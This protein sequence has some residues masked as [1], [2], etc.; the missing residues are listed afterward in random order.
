MNSNPTYFDSLQRVAAHKADAYEINLAILDFLFHLNVER[1][2]PFFT[3]VGIP[4]S[5]NEVKSLK[6]FLKE[7]LKE[8]KAIDVDFSHN[9]QKLDLYL[10]KA[11]NGF[12]LQL[13]TEKANSIFDW[14]AK[15]W[16]RLPGYPGQDTWVDLLYGL[17]YFDETNAQLL[18]TMRNKT[19]FRTKLE[20]AFMEFESETHSFSETLSSHF[21]KSGPLS[22]WEKYLVDNC[23]M[24]LHFTKG[25]RLADLF[26][27]QAFCR[28]WH[29]ITTENTRKEVE[30]LVSWAKEEANLMH[31]PSKNLELVFS[32]CAAAPGSDSIKR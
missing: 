11:R 4:I 2:D 30:S 22:D 1:L 5:L 12:T 29:K 21:E 16:P 13:G 19:R 31:Y 8:W 7:W 20:R 28:L 26:E 25:A 15:H 6:P 27:H 10:P 3:R 24:T 23:D 32:L 18:S 17:T 14:A 9:Q